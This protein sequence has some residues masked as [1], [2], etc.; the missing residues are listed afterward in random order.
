M[1]TNFPLVSVIIPAYN[2]EDYLADA[3]KSVLAQTYINFELIVVDDGSIDGTPLIL[4]RF[5]DQVIAIRQVN[6]GV[7]AARNA[8]L[9]I[10]NGELLA[11]LDADDIW[12]P[13]KLEEQVQMFVSSDDP[14]LGIVYSDYETANFK[15][16]ETFESEVKPL[17]R[18]DVFKTLLEEGNRISGSCSSVMM[19]KSVAE[20]VFGFDEKL[21]FA[22]D[23]DMWLR[24]AEKFTFDF[25]NKPLVIIR[26]NDKSVQRTITNNH[27]MFQ[28]NIPFFDKHAESLNLNKKAILRVK[29][30]Y[31][32]SIMEMMFSDKRNMI[33]HAKNI[34]NFK[35]GKFQ[36]IKWNDT[37]LVLS[38][39]L[40]FFLYRFKMKVKYYVTKD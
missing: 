19:K 7:N 9:R 6:K 29:N 2:A 25:V 36:L 27:M 5:S 21:K 23:L 4:N 28:K 38:S 37:F 1:N 22:E 34:F 18:G 33:F 32:T 31:I 13:N 35:I 16:T 40:R 11:F 12:K 24:I 30:L 8:G 15:L 39:F 3:I 26:N 10:A 17:L 20:K 14:S